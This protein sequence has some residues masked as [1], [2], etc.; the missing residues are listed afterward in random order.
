MKTSGN[1]S[2]LLR[3]AA[4]LRFLCVA[5]LRSGHLQHRHLPEALRDGQR[6]PDYVHLRLANTTRALLPPPAQAL[7][8]IEIP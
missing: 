7:S 4:R 2:N 5:I 8:T 3:A 6:A 1:S